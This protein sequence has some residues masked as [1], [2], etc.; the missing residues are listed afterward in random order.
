MPEQRVIRD[1]IG[2]GKG[3]PWTEPSYRGEVN[4]EKEYPVSKRIAESTTW[5]F[6]MFMWRNGPQEVK[7]TVD[8]FDKVFSQL[9][10]VIDAYLRDRTDGQSTAT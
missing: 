6:N 1:K 2:Y 5:L 7:Q 3:S 4:Y 8:A 9:K 10:G